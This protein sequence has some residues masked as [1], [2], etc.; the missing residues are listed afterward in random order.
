MSLGCVSVRIAEAFFR[1]MRRLVRQ[2]GSAQLWATTL[3]A[4]AVPG[5]ALLTCRHLPVKF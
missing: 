1:R 4:L 5:L 3:L 2:G